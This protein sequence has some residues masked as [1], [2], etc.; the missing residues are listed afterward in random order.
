MAKYIDADALLSRLPDDLPYK[1]SVK[2]VLM[3]APTADVVELPCKVGDTVYEIRV[4]EGKIIERIVMDI[5]YDGRFYIRLRPFVSN[6]YVLGKTVFLT[7]EEA[8][9]ALRKEREK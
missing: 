7:R 5:V 9:E 2:R 4:Q 6:H 3:Q 1:G 8:K